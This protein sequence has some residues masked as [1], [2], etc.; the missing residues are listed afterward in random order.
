MTNMSNAFMTPLFPAAVRAVNALEPAHTRFKNKVL[1][2]AELLEEAMQAYGRCLLAKAGA[3]ILQPF[4]CSDGRTIGA[5]SDSGSDAA[6]REAEEHLMWRGRL[7]D[8]VSAVAVG[9]NACIDR[10]VERAT[11][12]IDH[13]MYTL[14]TVLAASNVHCLSVASGIHG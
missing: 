11:R 5:R 1:H 13:L 9:G 8:A 3:P 14:D 4:T 7:R 10:A 2:V 12:E 6:V